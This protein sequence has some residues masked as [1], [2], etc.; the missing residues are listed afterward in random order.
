[1]LNIE[2]EDTIDIKKNSSN[3]LNIQSVSILFSF[4]VVLNIVLQVILKFLSENGLINI[5]SMN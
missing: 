2:Y 1:M 5:E 3:R 4:I